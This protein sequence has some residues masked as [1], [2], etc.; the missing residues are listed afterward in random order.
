MTNTKRWVLVNRKTSKASRSFATR[1]AAR[2]AKTTN[3]R[4]YDKLTGSFVR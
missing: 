1:D 3:F 4:I 2:G